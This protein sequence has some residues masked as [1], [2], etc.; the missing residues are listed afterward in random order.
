[1][2]PNQHNQFPLLSPALQ[3]S[4]ARVWTHTLKAVRWLTVIRS[5][6]DPDN[7][8]A[9]LWRRSLL[10]LIVDATNRD[11]PRGGLSTAVLYAVGLEVSHNTTNVKLN[12]NN[13]NS[14]LRVVATASA[15]DHSGTWK[16]K[17]HVSLVL[18]LRIRTIY[19]RLLFTCSH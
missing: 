11:R 7:G 4:L 18:R 1:M 6:Y 16:E 12:N 8:E 9:T 10:H 3:P 17:K 14:Y 15:K 2:N 5:I 13:N 19:C